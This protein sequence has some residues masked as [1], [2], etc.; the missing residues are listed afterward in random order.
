MP[1]D[2]TVVVGQVSLISND[3]FESRYQVVSIIPHEN[4]DNVLGLNNL[5]VIEVGIN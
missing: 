3:P 1:Y 2:V 5:A 4:Y